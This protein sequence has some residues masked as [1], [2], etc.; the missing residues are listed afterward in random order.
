MGLHHS[1]TT[2]VK[3][4]AVTLWAFSTALLVFGTTHASPADHL[5]VLSWSLWVQMCAWGFTAWWIHDGLHRRS[6]IRVTELAEIMARVAIEEPD[7]A[8]PRLRRVH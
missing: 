6:Q 4:A 2:A 8:Q 5:A 7:P 1:R 3:I